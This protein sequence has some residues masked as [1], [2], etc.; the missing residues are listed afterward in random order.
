MEPAALRGL[1]EEYLQRA[2]RHRRT[3]R[4]FFVDKKPSNFLHLGLILLILPNAKIIDARR[5]P[6]A[7]CFSMFK[8]YFKKPR[9]RQAELGRFYRDYVE[10]MAHFDRIAP[11]RVHRVIYEEM[12]TE[13]EEQ[14]RKL[15]DYLGLPFEES[16]LR[17]Y[18]TKRSVLTPSSEQVRRPI[19]REGLDQWR[20]YEQWLGT[21]KESLGT[22]LKAYP[23]VPEELR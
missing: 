21:L 16:C 20:N 14:T 19:S 8:Q 13:P 6:I 11:D 10:L 23:A 5:H 22:V 2:W 9:P 4:P 15:L 18:E 3:A 12:V 17:F 1:G 7:C